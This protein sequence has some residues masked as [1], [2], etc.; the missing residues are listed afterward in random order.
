MMM[1]TLDLFLIDDNTLL[2]RSDKMAFHGD[3]LKT[4]E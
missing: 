4:P 1:M 3:S 2:F